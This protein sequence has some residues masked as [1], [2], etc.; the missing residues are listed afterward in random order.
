MDA[1]VTAGWYHA[2]VEIWDAATCAKFA[3][4][5]LRDGFGTPAP[6]PGLVTLPLT[7]RYNG[8]TVIADVWY[9]GVVHERPSLAAGYEWV[10]VPSWGWRIVASTH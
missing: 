1:D 3:K 8:G 5:L 4:R 7:Q 10:S 6:V 2:P 9:A